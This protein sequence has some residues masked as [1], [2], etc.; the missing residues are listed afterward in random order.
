[1]G[2]YAQ[3]K[4]R[5]IGGPLDTSKAKPLD[6]KLVTKQGASPDYKLDLSNKPAASTPAETATPST[7]LPS[8]PSVPTPSKPSIPDAPNLDF[9][10]V[11]KEVAKDKATKEVKAEVVK[12]VV[13]NRGYKVVRKVDGKRTELGKSY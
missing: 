10:E 1:M 12:E 7:S 9:Q 13:N 3:S 6:P 5:R 4:A 8:L 11:S 2:S